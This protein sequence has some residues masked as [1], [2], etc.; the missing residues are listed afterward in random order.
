MVNNKIRANANHLRRELQWFSKLLDARFKQYFEP[1]KRTRGYI[2]IE[3]P[4]FK[5]GSS[6]YAEFIDYYKLSMPERIVLIL[7]LTPHV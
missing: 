1:G 7:S 4:V 3:P 2:R 6:L 5:K